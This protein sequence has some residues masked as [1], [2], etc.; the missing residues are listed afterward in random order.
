LTGITLP[1]RRLGRKPAFKFFAT[2]VMDGQDLVFMSGIVDFDIPG[3]TI[4][5]ADITDGLVIFTPTNQE[6]NGP[7]WKDPQQVHVV[8]S[9]SL[10]DIVTGEPTFPRWAVFSCTS[11]IVSNFIQLTVHIGINDWN[12]RF[13]RLA[14]HLTALGTL[15]K[16]L[17]PDT[18]RSPVGREDEPTFES[19]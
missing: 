12:A 6:R 3:R 5:P 19:G 14:Y 7:I 10:A 8:P 18:T 2:K 9:A 11:D 15:E 1:N 16:P 13:F 17:A 4:G